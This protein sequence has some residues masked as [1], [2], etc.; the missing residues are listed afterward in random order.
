MLLICLGS[1][2]AADLVPPSRPTSVTRSSR[3]AE[4]LDSIRNRATA[5]EDAL[6]TNYNSQAQA[7]ANLKKL[8]ALIKLRSQERDL[9]R[10]RL[11]ELTST[12]SELMARRELLREKLNTQKNSVRR[13]LMAIEG[14]LRADSGSTGASMDSV[15]SATGSEL[16]ESTIESEKFEAPRRKLMANLVSHGLKEVETLHADLDDSDQLEQKIDEEKQ[17]LAYLFQDLDEKES[18]LELN[19]QI[20]SDILHKSRNERI[21]QLENYRMLKSSQTQV[22]QMMQDFSARRELERTTEEERRSNSAFLSAFAQLKGKLQLPVDGGRVVSSFG[23]SFDPKSKLFIFKKGIDIA[24]AL[25]AAPRGVV[26]AVFDGKIAYSGELPQYGQVAIVDHG[27]H[28]YTLCA[29]LGQLTH[30]AGDRVAAGDAIGLTDDVGTPVYFE[31]RDRNVA[32]NPL[33][34]VS[35]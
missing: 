27:N 8:Q 20:Q 5:L 16:L 2:A 15:E 19:R 6:I 9:G 24:P 30:K 35:N 14:S 33:Q 3:Y 10:Q 11:A 31:I 34:W 1:S 28:F 12:V 7:K 17:H 21:A 32:V 13:L 29:H 26:R 25:H 4:Q 22:E 23:R 18:V